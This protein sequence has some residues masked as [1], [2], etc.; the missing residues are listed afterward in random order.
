M[1]GVLDCAGF[2]A[3]A[4]S[5]NP[6]ELEALVQHIEPDAIVYDVS[7]PFTENWQQ[8]QCLRSRLSLRHVPFVI[9]TSE[10]RELFRRTGATALEL[11]SRPDDLA[12]FQS[13]VRNAIEAAA[14]HHAA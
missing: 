2:V 13:A 12:A 11:F 8:L 9:T 4:T 7:Y 6:S 10:A 14:P 3:T 1:K 5:S